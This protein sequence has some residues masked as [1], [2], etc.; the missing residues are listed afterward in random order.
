MIKKALKNKNT[1]K[2]SYIFKRKKIPHVLTK[3]NN[4]QRKIY[5]TRENNIRCIYIMLQP[6]RPLIMWP[7]K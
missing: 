4:L 7:L 6:Y 3:A 2:K 5:L 1:F